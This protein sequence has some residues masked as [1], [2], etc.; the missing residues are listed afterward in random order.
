[1]EIVAIHKEA[2]AIRHGVGPEPSRSRGDRSA[3]GKGDRLGQGA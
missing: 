1:M 3:L 2:P